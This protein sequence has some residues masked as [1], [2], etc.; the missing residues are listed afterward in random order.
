MKFWQRALFVICT[1]V[2]SLHS[3]YMKNALVFSQSEA[4]NYFIYTRNG[5]ITVCVVKSQVSFSNLTSPTWIE[6]YCEILFSRNSLGNL[7]LWE[8]SYSHPP[9][10]VYRSTESVFKTWIYAFVVVENRERST[11]RRSEILIFIYYWKTLFES[12]G[13][14]GELVFQNRRFCKEANMCYIKINWKNIFFNCC[15]NFQGHLSFDAGFKTT[16]QTPLYVSSAIV[17]YLQPF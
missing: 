15:L 8:D 9:Y 16:L 17:S 5:I 12:M 1:R 10:P 7:Y 3:C 2:A 6:T 4:R 14:K 13:W 11:F